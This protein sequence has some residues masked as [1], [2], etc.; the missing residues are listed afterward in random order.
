MGGQCERGKEVGEKRR[1]EDLCVCVC[2]CVCV[3]ASVCISRD[4]HIA[5]TYDISV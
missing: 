2:V 1:V 4:V 3:Y 5:E